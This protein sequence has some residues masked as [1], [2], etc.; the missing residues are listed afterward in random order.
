[1]IE[2]LRL[3]PP[4]RKVWQSLIA[5]CLLIGLGCVAVHNGHRLLGWLI[6]IVYGLGVVFAPRILLLP[7]ASWLELDE[8]GFTLCF[9]FKTERY[10]WSHITELSVW[11]GV[12]SFKL[13]PEHRGKH[14]GQG[15]ARSISGYDGSI[16][17]IFWLPPQSL[18]EMMMKFK[19]N[20]S[21]EPTR[22][23]EG[24]RGSP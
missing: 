23:P 11:L 5:C 21:V 6:I 22:A 8:E 18:L 14:R 20:Q 15:L 10:L 1:M 24:A 16:P 4:T 3:V 12:V 17:N 7:G 13:A 2:K 9:S 19:Q